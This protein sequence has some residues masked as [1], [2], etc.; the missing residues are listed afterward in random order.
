M[1]LHTSTILALTFG[2]IF[3]CQWGYSQNVGI[4]TAVPAEKLHVAGSARVDNL[5]GV[6]T[7]VVGSDVNGTLLNVG[8]GTNGQVLMQTPTGPA[9]QAPTS[10]NSTS[11]GADIQV[12]GATWGNVAGMTV[13]FT[14]TQT[15]ALLMFSGSGFA[16]T[17]SMAYVQFR[18]RNGG[19]SLGGTNTHMQSYDDVTG[20]TTPWSCTYTR[21]I[22]G[23]VIGT[24]YTYTLQG[25]VGGILGTNNAAIF[26]ATNPDFHHLTLTVL[27]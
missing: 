2:T 6:G 17:N 18:I 14:A 25:Q 20:T 1:K 27:Q 15:D 8:P 12:T 7:R 24:L 4:G 21:K 26:A 13:T 23:L 16:W 5:S 9:Y 3:S 11:L 22:T 19:T 10:F